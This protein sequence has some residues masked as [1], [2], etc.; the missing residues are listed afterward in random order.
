VIGRFTSGDEAACRRE[1]ADLVSWC[2]D[3]N[4]TLKTDKTKEMI[5]DMRKE[6]R[7]HQPLF[8]RELAVERV[9]TFNYLGVHISEDLTTQ[10]VKK[11]QRWLY[12][13]RRLRKCGMAA[14]I[15]RNFYS[16]VVESML[17]SCITQWGY[18]AL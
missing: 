13:L 12:F 15:L 16:C 3:N 2:E 17:T 7:P 11:A 10:L 8:I 9:S 18:M 14:E 5:V 1:A 6:R 4:L